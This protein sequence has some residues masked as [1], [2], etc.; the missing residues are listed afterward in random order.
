VG[1][2]K[3]QD[4][5]LIEYPVEGRWHPVHWAR[6]IKN[7]FTIDA[8]GRIK[9]PD[10]PGLGIEIDMNI[11]KRFGKRIYNGTP[12]SVAR[13]TLFDRGLKQA[14]FLK[15]KKK[16]QENRLEKAEFK[17]PEAPF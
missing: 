15:N 7:D 11:I 8:E 13:F 2:L 10:E 3:E 17:I 12:A 5:S 9:I 14:I 1:V 6:F 4:R 16:E